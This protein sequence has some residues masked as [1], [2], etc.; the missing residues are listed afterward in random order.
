MIPAKT[1]EIVPLPQVL[2]SAAMTI[3]G[4]IATRAGDADLS[5]EQD[6]MEVHEL[7][8]S[9][10]AIMVGIGTVL[11]D[12]PKLRVKYFSNLGLKVR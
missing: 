7:R 8:K 5:D 12:D 9:H 1:K 6:W 2:Y 10:D 4:K 3:D 11:A